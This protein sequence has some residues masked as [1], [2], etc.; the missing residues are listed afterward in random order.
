MMER[1]A[2]DEVEA[3]LAR[4]L[5]QD[6]PVMRA[7]GVPEISAYLKGTMSRAE[8]ITLGKI[9]TRQYAKRQFTWF[10]NQAPAA[11]PRIVDEINDS[12]RGYFETIFQ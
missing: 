12:N 5:P 6:A 2:I 3:L 1:G 10:R 9:A 8:A 11:W 7:I 4:N